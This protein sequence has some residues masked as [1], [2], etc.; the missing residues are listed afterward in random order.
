[1]DEPESYQQRQIETLVASIVDGYSTEEPPVP[2]E[3]I[4]SDPPRGL[5]RIDISD[6]SLIFGVGEHE[7]EYRLALGRLLYRE[8]CRCGRAGDLPYT[9]DVARQFATALLMPREWIRTTARSPRITLHR[10]SEIYQ[11]PEYAVAR[12]LVQLGLR[13]PGMD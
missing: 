3:K 5:S 10:L 12:R 9:N 4:L 11:V 6:L 1:M 13:V 8:L 2:I 7:H